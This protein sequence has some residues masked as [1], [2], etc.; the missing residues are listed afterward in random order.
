LLFLK[1]SRALSLRTK[2]DTFGKKRN[3]KHLATREDFKSEVSKLREE[4]A[5]TRLKIAATKVELTRAVY[6]VGLVQF[7]AIVG[8]V[9]ALLN[10][11]AK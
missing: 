10:F 9:L 11:V 6:V 1:Q 3:V 8:S 4:I 7:L 2:V 5:G